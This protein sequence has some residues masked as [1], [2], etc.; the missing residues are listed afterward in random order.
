MQILESDQALVEA[1]L[2]VEVKEFRYHPETTHEMVLKRYVDALN[3]E[4]E[5]VPA[6]DYL[7]IQSLSNLG[8]VS[9]ELKITPT[10]YKHGEICTV[11]LPPAPPPRGGL[12]ARLDVVRFTTYKEG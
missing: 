8:V 4:I 9:R 2:M 5:K 6:A 7:V 10:P 11:L 12:T 1:F 3:A